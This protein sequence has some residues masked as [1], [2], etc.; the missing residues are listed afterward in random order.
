MNKYTRLITPN[1]YNTSRENN[2]LI[3]Q[4]RTNPTFVYEEFLKNPSNSLKQQVKEM[5][6]PRELSLPNKQIKFNNTYSTETEE[7]YKNNTSTNNMN[8]MH[9]TERKMEYDSNVLA[10]NRSRRSNNVTD[11]F[12]EVIE[13]YRNKNS[14]IEGIKNKLLKIE[15]L[16]Y[17]VENFETRSKRVNEKLDIETFENQHLNFVSPTNIYKIMADRISEGSLSFICNENKGEFILRNK[18]INQIKTKRLNME[19]KNQFYFG[20]L[21]RLV[22][23]KDNFYSYNNNNPRQATENHDTTTYTSFCTKKPKYQSNKKHDESDDFF[24]WIP[25]SNILP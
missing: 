14:L 4:I 24:F 10:N 12:S 9:P 3:Q 6:T 8:L 22:N 11:Y 16:V 23:S 17:P 20:N 21:S 2:K 7:I 5:N 18:N 25:T 15:E 13:N 19:G 1:K